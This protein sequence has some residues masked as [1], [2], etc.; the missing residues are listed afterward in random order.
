MKAK[1]LKP[2]TPATKDILLAQKAISNIFFYT[3]YH[4]LLKALGLTPD[5]VILKNS[6]EP[7]IQK[8]QTGKIVY[9]SGEFSGNFDSQ[10]SKAIKSLGGVFNKKTHTYKIL[11]SKLPA[12]VRAAISVQIIANNV[13]RQRI[14]KTIE[15]I[16]LRF[17]DEKET[18]DFR[19][20][21][22]DAT[23]TTDS[24]LNGQLAP[25]LVVVPEI[26]EYTA[27][28]LQREYS[29]SINLAIKNFT[30]K[31]TEKLREI[32]QENVF[33]GFRADKLEQAIRQRFGISQRRAKFIASQE[34]QILTAKYN[35]AKCV[36]AGLN[37]YIWR[38]QGDSH[39]RPDHARLNGK[40]FDYNN[41]PETD[42]TTHAHNNPSED[43]N[44]RCYAETLVEA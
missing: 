1:T 16:N 21:A 22:A 43:Y 34:T 24:K 35:T 17:T 29:E 38:T 12:G 15:E 4:P 6:N 33:E 27:E 39:V 10:T 5:E 13:K 3:I 41:P 8:I 11:P 9:N 20:I 40:E 26:T 37:K 31:E 42:L 30:Q 19:A 44:C 32:A 14:L 2:I 18:H 25:K 7:I 23:K 36:Q 28:R